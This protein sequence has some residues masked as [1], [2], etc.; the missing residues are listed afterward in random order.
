MA[1]I[2]MQY[3]TPY[4]TEILITEMYHWLMSIEVGIWKA[5]SIL[6][7]QLLLMDPLISLEDCT[8]EGSCTLSRKLKFSRTYIYHFTFS[9]NFKTKKK[10]KS[11]QVSDR[12]NRRKSLHTSNPSP[13]ISWERY[14]QSLYI[15]TATWL[16]LSSRRSNFKCQ[17]T[18]LVQPQNC[19]TF[20]SQ[21]YAYLDW[22]DCFTEK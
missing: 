16:T 3:Y 10:G 13:K 14:R 7:G 19:T 15:R 21:K 11:G 12:T 2:R 18:K 9:K 6:K 20:P 1:V 4:N 5:F 8:G 22:N 17:K